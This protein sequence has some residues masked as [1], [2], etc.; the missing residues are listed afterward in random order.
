[1]QLTMIG[2]IAEEN[3]KEIPSHFP[4]AEVVALIVMPNHVHGVILMKPEEAAPSIR[5]QSGIQP[6]GLQVVIRNYKAAVTFAARQR[7]HVGRVWQR[8]Y[9]DR[10]LRSERELWRACEY[11]AS[12]PSRWET[13]KENPHRRHP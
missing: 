9:Y 12:N 4:S 1:V 10:I 3:W 5:P 6:Q 11:I 13:D 2:R 8:G 7:G